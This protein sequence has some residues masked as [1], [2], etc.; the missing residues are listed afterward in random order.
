[1]KRQ[2]GIWGALVE[3]TVLLVSSCTWLQ[4]KS[5]VPM[6]SDPLRT[7]E[8]VVAGELTDEPM[9]HRSHRRRRVAH[10]HVGR[11]AE[12][13]AERPFVQRGIIR[14]PLCGL[15][16]LSHEARYAAEVCLHAVFST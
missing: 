8:V 7:V 6:G 15:Q 1:M 14:G 4:P 2:L 5:L 13:R 9:N 11:T 10:V 16:G 12:H 3:L